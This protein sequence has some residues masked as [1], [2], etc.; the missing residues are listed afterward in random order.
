MYH[1]SRCRCAPLFAAAAAQIDERRVARGE[2]ICVRRVHEYKLAAV[3]I[4]SGHELYRISLGAA[5]GLVGCR[6]SLAAC[7]R[8]AHGGDRTMTETISDKAS[9]DMSVM[10]TI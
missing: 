2:Y 6:R 4:V 3:N 7:G 5:G 8:I 9:S 10:S 1:V